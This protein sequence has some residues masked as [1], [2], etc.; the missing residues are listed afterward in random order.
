MRAKEFVAKAY[1]NDYIAR[2]KNARCRVGVKLKS[3]AFDA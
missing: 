1:M 2:L 3:I